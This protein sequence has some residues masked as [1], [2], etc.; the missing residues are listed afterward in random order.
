MTDEKPQE[1]SAKNDLP[2]PWAKWGATKRFGDG[3][4]QPSAEAKKAGWAKRRR[5][6]E[7]ARLML[8]MKF[9]GQVVDLNADGSPKKDAKGNIILIDSP[10]KQKLIRYF[11]LNEDQ[12][13]ELSNEAAIMLRMIGQ[14]I[15]QGDMSGAQAILDRA[16]GKP[17]EYI[18]LKDDDGDRPVINV[19][20]VAKL[21]DDI[22]MPEISESENPD[23]DEIQ[24]T[25]N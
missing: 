17:K 4:S 22:D 12:M 5:N 18:S 23:K 10:F 14:A 25:N 19:T 7:L 8:G 11:G 21:P 3:Q 20:V 6:M 15:E 13:S 2:K 24:E 1:D 9:V 16:Y